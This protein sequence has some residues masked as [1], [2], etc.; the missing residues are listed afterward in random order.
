LKKQVTYIP[1][2]PDSKFEP[3]SK[4]LVKTG[5]SPGANPESVTR[6][7]ENGT[8]I[9]EVDKSKGSACCNLF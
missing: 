5:A 9:T 8:V 1:G 2:S 3:E 4:K 7:D 6:I